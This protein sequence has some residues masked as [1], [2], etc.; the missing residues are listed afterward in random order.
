M[1]IYIV[2]LSLLLLV[3]CQVNKNKL[4]QE[5]NNYSFFVGTY[6]DG[7]SKGIYKYQ[8]QQDGELKRIGLAVESVNPS[9]LA[10]SANKKFLLAVNEI[11]QNG[12]GSVESFLIQEDS[13]VFIS[14]RSSGGE[15]PCFVSVNKAGFVLTAN[16]SSGNVGLLRLDN[17]GEL[18]ALLDVNQ[19]LGS[20]INE[21]Q[22]APH[23]HSIWFESGNDT[24]ISADLGTN[25]LWFSHLDTIQQ[26]L[27]S[28][29]PYKLSMAP[30]A[31]PRHIAFHPNGKWI[32]V[33]N[34]LACTITLVEKVDN[35]QYKMGNSISTL[36]IDYKEL[37][38]SAD[39]HITSDGKFLYASNRGHN[40]IVIYNVTNDGSLKIIGY[41]S[42]KGNGPR[43]FSL[44]PGDKYVLVANQYTNNIVAFKRDKTTGLLTYMSQIEVPS[45]VCILF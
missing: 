32:Y 27:I 2:I 41:Q 36:P 30:G 23:A 35:D 40:S 28:I 45:P 31:G 15:H 24:I 7:D 20:G 42:T 43:N 39:I 1:K 38:T 12:E 6:T 11:N 18:T 19:H 22:E 37:N 33:L 10:M 44:S 9:F 8:L 17:K 14:K 21:R 16:Y 25:E 5:N 3:G 29:K 26:K 34:E 4:N 13:L